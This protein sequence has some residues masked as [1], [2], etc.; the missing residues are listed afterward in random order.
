MGYGFAGNDSETL[1]IMAEEPGE[2]KIPVFSSPKMKW[3]GEIQGDAE[4]ADAVTALNEA[5]ATVGRLYEQLFENLGLTDGIFDPF[6]IPQE[7]PS[8][9]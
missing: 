2:I 5:A 7:E 4:S 9:P 1:T 8:V 3:E 6:D